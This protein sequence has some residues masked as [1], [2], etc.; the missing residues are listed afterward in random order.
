MTDTATDP[1]Y[2]AINRDLPINGE[3]D[4]ARTVQVSPTLL[5][6]VDAYGYVVGVESL[7]GV[8]GMAEMIRIFQTLPVDPTAGGTR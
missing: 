6:D 7:T 3:G 5:V 1:A 2:L 4:V 8:V